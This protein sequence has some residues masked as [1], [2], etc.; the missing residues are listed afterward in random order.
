MEMRN[1]AA[2]Q[3]SDL[4]QQLAWIDR[5]IA[6]KSNGK[7][8][9]SYVASSSRPGRR[10]SA[11]REAIVNVLGSRE[12]GRAWAPQEVRDSLEATHG[13]DSTPEAVRVLLRRML[14]DGEVERGGKNNMGWKL[15]S[16][17][18][19][20]EAQSDEPR[21]A[22]GYAPEGALTPGSG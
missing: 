7:P 16:D 14:A 15:P 12:R 11:K 4:Q 19:T 10:R 3:I 5:A 8:I 6:E 2:G 21:S 9:G 17:N 1:D 13:I 20:T 18:A 22:N